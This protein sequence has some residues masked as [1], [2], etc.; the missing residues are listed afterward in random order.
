MAGDYFGQPQPGVVPFLA[1]GAWKH[2][3]TTWPPRARRAGAL[4][5]NDR[6]RYIYAHAARN[7]RPRASLGSKGEGCGSRLRVQRAPRDSPLC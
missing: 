6:W 4:T 5:I 2:I 7:T 1:I 3:T